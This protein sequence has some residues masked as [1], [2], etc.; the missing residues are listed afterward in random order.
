MKRPLFAVLCLALSTVC[1]ADRLVAA[2]QF[3]TPWKLKQPGY[4]TVDVRIWG[5]EYYQV[6]E[7]P[8]GYTLMR[9]PVT[10]VIVYAKLSP[11][12][13]ELV[14]TGVRV[15]SQ[16]PLSLGLATHIRI[17]ATVAADQA[18]AARE[19]A[20]PNMADLTYGVPTQA[21]PS[22]GN[23]KGLVLIADFS[24]QVATI[25]QAEVVNFCNQVGYS[26]FGNNGSV[27]DYFSDV[28]DGALNYTQTVNAVYHR[29]SQ[30]FSYYD[31]CTVPWLDRAVEL[32]K[33][34]LNEM[35][36]NGF[37][38]SQYD[39][40]GDGN[41]DAINLFYAGST[42]CGCQ[43]HVAGRGRHGGLFGR[44]QERHTLPDHRHGE[45]AL[46]RDLLPRERP[47]DLLLSGSL[48][49]RQ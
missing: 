38:F 25:T 26:G 34:I 35:E 4:G 6:V 40:N 43:G 17:D 12:G 41:I 27:H 5:D 10:S 23:V 48:R 14:S 47:H 15:G 33:E 2:P 44:R 37:D 46:D 31:D 45:L 1:I 24:D 28:S 21:P 19:R 18:R 20:F 29:A 3:G 32:I 30:P 13:N 11:D 42:G 22:T 36:T 16:S 8:D 49:L 39:S 7:S 9:D